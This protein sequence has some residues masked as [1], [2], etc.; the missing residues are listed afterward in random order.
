MANLPEKLKSMPSMGLP[1]LNVYRNP[2]VLVLIAFYVL[3]GGEALWGEA[4]RRGLDKSSGKVVDNKVTNDK[5]GLWRFEVSA[6]DDTRDEEEDESALK[7]LTMRHSLMNASMNEEARPKSM[8]KQNKNLERPLSGR[9]SSSFSYISSYVW[10]KW[11][12]V[13]GLEVWKVTEDNVLID[14]VRGGTAQFVGGAEATIV[15]PLEVLAPQTGG[16]IG[17]A[18]YSRV[19]TWLVFI[20][21]AVV[22]LLATLLRNLPSPDEINEKRYSVAVRTNTS[23]F[24][25]RLI[26]MVS[27]SLVSLTLWNPVHGGTCD[28]PYD[29]IPL[30]SSALDS[31]ESRAGQIVSSFDNIGFAPTGSTLLVSDFLDLDTAIYTPLFGDAASRTTWTGAVAEG[32]VLD[33]EARLNANRAGIIGTPLLELACNHN[34]E[35]QRFRIDLSVTGTATGLALPTFDAIRLGILPEAVFHPLT[36]PTFTLS[37]ALSLPLVV[38]TNLDNFML[39][40]TT[41]HMDVEASMSQITGDAPIDCPIC[42]WFATAASALGHTTT[43]GSPIF[44]FNGNFIMSGSFDYSSVGREASGEGGFNADLNWYDTVQIVASDDDMFDS[45]PP[46]VRYNWPLCTYTSTLTQSINSMSVS[47]MSINT[48]IDN[49]FGLNSTCPAEVA[50]VKERV[51]SLLS[52]AAAAKVN[53]IKSG[54]T[55]I[56]AEFSTAC[57]SLSAAWTPTA[58]FFQLSDRIRDMDPDINS[59]AVGYFPGREELAMD[60]TIGLERSMAQSDWR[61]VV[62]CVF[63]GISDAQKAMFTTADNT[64]DVTGLMGAL[65][66]EAGFE[67]S[68]R[69][70]VHVCFFHDF[71]VYWPSCGAGFA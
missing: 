63:D 68:I 10:N 17:L 57:T 51:K 18:M 71:F 35:G 21:A 40:E 45:H 66:M 7:E 39:G 36:A 29:Y 56:I 24:R 4:L 2:A 43:F 67:L 23:R 44:T 30:L 14:G 6:S 33:V 11:M 26:R 49:H 47:D 32:G 55:A 50:A 42:G 48:A 1:I 34:E 16:G 64:V 13:I 41:A 58:T 46:T 3:G 5:G 28:V 54:I 53:Q 8:R 65:A 70:V 19:W 25:G 12:D 22:G 59:V 69:Y 15:A 62:D 60:F 9:D 27:S 52:S 37:Y 31:L 20:V 38:D 61:G